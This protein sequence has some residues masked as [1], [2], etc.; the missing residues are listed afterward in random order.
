MSEMQRGCKRDM[1]F[2]DVLEDL[3]GEFV[4]V[5]V[6]SGGECLGASEDDCCCSQEGTLCG[7]GEDFLLLINNDLKILIPFDAIAAIRRQD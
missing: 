3:V 1:D 6:M 5:I 2:L 4:T 7:I